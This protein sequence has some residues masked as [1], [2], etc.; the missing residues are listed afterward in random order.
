MDV[1]LGVC[2]ALVLAGPYAVGLVLDP[3]VTPWG[4]RWISVLPRVPEAGS[5]REVG[6]SDTPTSGVPASSHGEVS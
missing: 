3:T 5:V 2:V 6:T 1:A 4:Y